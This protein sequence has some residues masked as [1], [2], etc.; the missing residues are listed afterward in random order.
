MEADPA[1]LNLS[2]F[3]S[4]YPERRPFFIEGMQIFR[5]STFGGDGAGPG[6]FYSRRIGRALGEDRVPLENGERLVRAPQASTI[7][8]AVKVAGK[9]PGGLSVGVLQAVT[10]REFAVVEK[11]GREFERQVENEASYSL[12]R[13]RQD[14]LDGSSIGMIATAVARKSQLPCVHGRTRLESVRCDAEPWPDRIP[15]RIA[16]RE[17]RGNRSGG[18]AGNI[19]L[20]RTAAEHWLWSISADLTTKQYQINDIGFFRRPNDYGTFGTLTYKEDMPAAV[21][22][23]YTCHGHAA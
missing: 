15:R 3:E 18:I 21:V 19:E 7:L 6:L 16:H 23:R 12:V 1:V 2:T 14:V 11:D 20:S 9:T 5:F 13:L 8:G 17:T 4:F 22:R 10:D